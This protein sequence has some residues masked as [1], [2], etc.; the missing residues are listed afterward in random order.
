[1][2]GILV[3]NGATDWAFDV[4]PSFPE[5][6]YNFDLIPMPLFNNYTNSGCKVFFAD[7]IHKPEGPAYC[8]DLWN[9]ITDLTGDLNWYDL[10]RPKYHE[11]LAMTAEERIGKTVID[12]VERTYKKGYTHREYTPWMKKLFPLKEGAR[13]VVMGMNVSTYLNNATVREAFHIPSFV[14]AWE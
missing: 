5:V 9:Q 7:E 11:G 10:Y 14:P 6:A 2:T 12:G 3:G 8:H 1:M 4:S 13:E